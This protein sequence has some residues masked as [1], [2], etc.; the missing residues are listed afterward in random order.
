V[1][2]ASPRECYNRSM[3]PLEVARDFVIGKNFKK[4]IL[5]DMVAALL[6]MVDLDTAG[7]CEPRDRTDTPIP[8]GIP[9]IGG[10]DARPPIKVGAGLA[11]A[12]YLGPEA[13]RFYTRSEA[14]ALAG[15]IART[16][17]TSPP[18]RS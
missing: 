4:S 9:N 7:A 14:L 11:G 13:N 3:D 2:L 17:T 6:N 8:V 5:V 10:Y 18:T 12:V 16:A 1:T 15:A